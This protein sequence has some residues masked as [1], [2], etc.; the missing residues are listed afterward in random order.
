MYLL[1]AWPILHWL[2]IKCEMKYTFG[3]LSPLF[4]EC[5]NTCITISTCWLGLLLVDSVITFV[6]SRRK[7]LPFIKSDASYSFSI[8]NV[9]LLRSSILSYGG[10]SLHFFVRP[11]LIGIWVVSTF[12]WLL[13][14]S[15][16]KYLGR[17]LYGH[18]ISFLSV[19]YPEVEWLTCRGRH[20]F[21]Y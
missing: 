6:I 8:V 13:R 5:L 12:F 11:L 4:C 21:N 15:Y 1:G 20:M 17:D 16:Y 14:E 10:G 7:I 3:S 18:M 9:F 19:E 2:S